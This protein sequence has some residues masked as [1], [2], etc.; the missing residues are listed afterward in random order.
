MAPTAK[1][2][3]QG[4]LPQ[5]DAETCIGCSACISAC[6]SSVLDMVDSK[7]KVTKP[8]DCTSCAA[9]VS[10]CPVEAIKL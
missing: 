10:A 2:K 3:P 1:P 6:P 9:C 4:K 5:I 8:K 7:A